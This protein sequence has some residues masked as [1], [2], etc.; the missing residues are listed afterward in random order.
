MPK[1][2]REEA[3]EILEEAGIPLASPDDPIYERPPSVTFGPLSGESTSKTPDGSEPT[4]TSEPPSTGSTSQEIEAM[5][6]EVLSTRRITG[7][8]DF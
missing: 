7:G 3:L 6:K 4:P 5:V 8:S 2:T 1:L